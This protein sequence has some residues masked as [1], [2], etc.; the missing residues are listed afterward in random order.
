MAVIKKK[1][2]LSNHKEGIKNVWRLIG[3]TVLGWTH[4]N[5]SV[6][7][8]K[9]NNSV[10]HTRTIHII[11]AF[12]T[13]G[14]PLLGKQH[15]PHILKKTAEKGVFLRRLFWTSERAHSFSFFFFF[16]Y[17]FKTQ[18]KTSTTIGPYDFCNAEHIGNSGVQS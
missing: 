17:S 18:C 6:K 15:P 13:K 12:Q 11:A 4:W 16:F 2:R 10:E 1:G 7:P 5:L 14:Q 3:N 9:K 8:R